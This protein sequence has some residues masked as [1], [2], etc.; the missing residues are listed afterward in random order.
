MKI[1]ITFFILFMLLPNSSSIIKNMIEAVYIPE[2][3]I[4]I[5]G[6]DQNNEKIVLTYNRSNNVLT[7]TTGTNSKPEKIK[8]IDLFLRLFF[9]TAE[10]MNKETVSKVAND[11]TEILK[12]NGID[13]SK[14]TP[15]ASSNNGFAGI[16]IG[17]EK[18]FDTANE[19][20][21]FKNS[22]LPAMLIIG[23]RKYVFSDYHKSVY[24]AA[25]PGKIEIYTEY[26]LETTLIFYSKEY[27]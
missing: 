5:E 23:K 21:L 22:Y 18:R 9:F 11:M 25:F 1:P 17:K 13:T 14:S 2:N 24:P 26:E 16:S 6:H 12:K 3:N 7:K 19:L 10:Q 15:S 20:V 8:E 4:K 27:L